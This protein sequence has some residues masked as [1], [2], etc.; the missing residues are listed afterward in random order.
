M[1][2]GISDLQKSVLR[3][4]YRNRVREFCLPECEPG[5]KP[6]CEALRTEV[7]IEHFG[8]PQI[9]KG[10]PRWRADGWRWPWHG[11]WI[12]KS[13]VGHRRYVSAH[14]SLSRSSLRLVR[15]GLINE[16]PWGYN[17]TDEGVRLCAEMFPEEA[18]QV[19]TCEKLK[20]AIE[21]DSP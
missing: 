6:P 20:H 16:D 12:R 15:R 19:V 18:D 8:F 2:R 13:A 14:A 9:W 4:A 5:V 10:S 1:G 17:L 7:L 11:Q 21:E 3:I